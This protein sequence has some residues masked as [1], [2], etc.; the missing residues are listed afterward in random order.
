MPCASPRARRCRPGRGRDPPPHPRRQSGSGAGRGAQ[1]QHGRG[2]DAAVGALQAL[3]G[4]GLL[5]SRKKVAVERFDGL[6]LGGELLAPDDVVGAAAV[7][8]EAEVL[9]L[10]LGLQQAP[11]AAR[12]PG[13]AASPRRAEFPRSCVPPVRRCRSRRWCWRWRIDFSRV[14]RRD[15]D[16]EDQAFGQVGDLRRHPAARAPWRRAPFG[17]PPASRP[18]RPARPRRVEFR[19]R[20]ASARHPPHG[21]SGRCRATRR[22]GYSATPCP[23]TPARSFH[24]NLMKARSDVSRTMDADAR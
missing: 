8:A 1:G 11:P 7:A 3:L 15:G 20:G 12:T 19:D 4:D 23:A 9:D 13:C 6:R 14:G 24:R 18:H 10:D 2:Q 22:S 16:L 5:Q 21:P 17:H